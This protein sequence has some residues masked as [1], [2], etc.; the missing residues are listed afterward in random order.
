[1]TDEAL[2]TLLRED[3]PRGQAALY[4]EYANYAYAVIARHIADGATQ[5]DIEDCFVETFTDILPRAAGIIGSIKAYVGTAARH[6]AIDHGIAIRKRI[7]RTVPLEEAAEPSF[8]HVEEEVEARAR[9]T[10][11]MEAVDALGEPDATILIQKYFYRRKM[12]D[13]GRMVGL[14]ANAAQVRCS[15]A[16][17]RLRRMLEE[18]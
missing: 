3:P 5:E 15:R 9:N 4:D 1:M 13:I 16:L 17:K 12:A 6:H 11:L 2:R 14:T 7:V 8:S 10:A 18:V